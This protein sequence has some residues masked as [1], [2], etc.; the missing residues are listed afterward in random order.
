MVLHVGGDLFRHKI[1]DLLN[2]NVL[3]GDELTI[4]PLAYSFLA[5]QS[6]AY[7]NTSK[8]AVYAGGGGLLKN[9]LHDSQS[10]Q[11]TSANLLVNMVEPIANMSDEKDVW[12]CP[13]MILN[14]VAETIATINRQ[15]SN[16]DVQPAADSV[17]QSDETNHATNLLNGDKLLFGRLMGVLGTISELFET[18]NPA[19]DSR[20]IS[21]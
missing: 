6:K 12:R 10:I 7:G 18:T 2:G 20:I 1:D 21:I 11:T 19:N 5:D 4:R 14:I 9:L 3:I 16:L 13:I 8:P 17:A 15:Y